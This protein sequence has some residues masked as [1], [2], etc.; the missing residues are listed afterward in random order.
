MDRKRTEAI[1]NE[2]VRVTAEANKIREDGEYTVKEFIAK[3]KAEAGVTLK[4]TT[5]RDRLDALVAA[6][7][8]TKRL[9]YL[10]ESRSTVCLYRPVEE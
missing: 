3:V 9:V 7:K 1:W 8:L 6:G 10:E 4:R 2:I 5:A